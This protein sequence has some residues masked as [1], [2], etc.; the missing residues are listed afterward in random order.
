MVVDEGLQLLAEA[1]RA[2]RLQ[3][4]WGKE[5]AARQA[6][7][8]SITWSRV[9]NGLPIRADRLG[10]VE[11]ALGWAPGTARRVMAGLPL[12]LAP[13][14][15]KTGTVGALLQAAGASTDAD[16]R[17]VGYDLDRELDGLPE[18]D[19]EAVRAQIRAL[20]RARGLP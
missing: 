5:H 12:E 6:S 1:V 2:E 14:S 9:E 3:K 19:V 8:S 18:E 17:P 16:P 10:A 15:G 4:G 20:R 13:G 11:H 7:M